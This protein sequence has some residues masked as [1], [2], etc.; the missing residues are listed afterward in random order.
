MRQG[1]FGFH[2]KILTILSVVFVKRRYA[3]L[4]GYSRARD[5]TQRA[6]GGSI[7]ASSGLIIELPGCIVNQWNYG[8]HLRAPLTGI[9]GKNK[10]RIVSIR[11]RLQ[12]ICGEPIDKVY[13]GSAVNEP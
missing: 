11:R 13:L 8:P 6:I 4:S 9:P 3:A 2:R 1:R 12:A 7:A 5:Q 10:R